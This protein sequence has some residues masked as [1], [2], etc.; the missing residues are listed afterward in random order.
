M[1]DQPPPSYVRSLGAFIAKWY[2]SLPPAT[3]FIILVCVALQIGNIVTGWGLRSTMCLA[4]VQ[5]ILH[6]ITNAHR[7]FSSIFIHPSGLYLIFNLLFFAPCGKLL[8]GQQGTLGALQA[9]IQIGVVANWI[10]VLLLGLPGLVLASIGSDCRSGLN[11][12]M[13]ALMTVE[14]NRGALIQTRRY[15]HSVL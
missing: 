3:A 10:Y 5:L 9:I 6:P 2:F 7:P 8:E 12:V 14:A 11:A 13:Y 1:A 15:E 4:P